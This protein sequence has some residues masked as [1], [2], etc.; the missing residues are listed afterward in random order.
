MASI[1]EISPKV[2]LTLLRQAK[3]Q[4]P[5]PRKSPPA[6]S[7]T[8]FEQKTRKYAIESFSQEILLVKDSLDSALAIKDASDG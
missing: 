2:L 7:K 3:P 6:P 5:P 1:T 4:R 8:L